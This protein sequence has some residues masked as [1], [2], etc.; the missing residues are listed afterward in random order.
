MRYFVG[1]LQGLSSKKC[2]KFGIQVHTKGKWRGMGCLGQKING[3]PGYSSRDPLHWFEVRILGQG[4]GWNIL[5][6][7]SILTLIHWNETFDIKCIVHDSS[8]CNKFCNYDPRLST[9]SC[10]NKLC[11]LIFRAEYQRLTESDH[12]IVWWCYFR[13]VQLQVLSE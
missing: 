1:K 10:I 12:G 8:Q 6:I 3:I 5:N 13:S 4:K 7:T 2:Q 9:T 11:R